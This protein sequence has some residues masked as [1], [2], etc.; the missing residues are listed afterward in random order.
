MAEGFM[1]AQP[2]NRRVN[3]GR[4]GF[5]LIEL[6]VVI[7]IAAI[8]LLFAVPVTNSVL[9]ANQVTTGTQMVVD[10]LSLARQTA[11]TRNRVVEVRFYD[12][13][14]LDRGNAT[15]AEVSAFE[16][17]IYDETNTKSSPLASVEHLPGG[18]LI[19]K[20]ETLSTLLKSSRAKTNWTTDDPK[21]S[22]PRG[23]GSSYQT[24]ALRFRPDGS[25]DL[26]AGSWFL[27]LHGSREA[28]S[29]PPNHAAVQIDPY[30]GSL[31]LYRPG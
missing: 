27:T 10:G 17:V 1:K 18:V 16:A 19:S 3:V 30:N 12:F 20:D 5:T 24:Y 29:P 22:L 28:G 8:L 15:T 2:R 25:T 26:G 31:R 9:T 7:T 23:I 14:S 11:I 4:N 21:Q 6:L 13:A